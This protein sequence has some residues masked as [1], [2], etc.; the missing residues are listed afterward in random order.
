MVHIILKLEGDCILLY[1]SAEMFY[2]ENCCSLPLVLFFSATCCKLRLKWCH[3]RHLQVARRT[4][5]IYTV[6]GFYFA[7]YKWTWS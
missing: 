4:T 7:I 6:I 3:S 5:S 2:F 1:S